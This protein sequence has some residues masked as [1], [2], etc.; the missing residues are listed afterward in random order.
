MI[1]TIAQS[2]LALG[3]EPIR[4]VAPVAENAAAVSTATGFPWV[5]AVGIV[6]GIAA[7]VALGVLAIGGISAYRRIRALHPEEQAFRAV[8]RTL[9]IPPTIWPEIRSLAK[10]IDAEPV[11]LLISKTAF[12]RAIATGT[13]ASESSPGLASVR[14]RL[15]GDDHAS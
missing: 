9:R 1:T 13:R 10:R 12:D 5:M 3:V 8:C 6:V 11:A 7:L 15:F 2:V 4:V 14:T